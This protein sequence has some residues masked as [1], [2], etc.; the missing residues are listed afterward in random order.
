MTRNYDLIFVIADTQEPFCHVDYLAFCHSVFELNAR[1][2]PSERVRVIHVG[3]EVDQHT[4]GRW[5][6]DPNGR[7]GGDEVEEAKLRLRD[8]YAAFPQASVCVSNHSYRVFKKAQLAGIPSQF[9]KSLG[10]VYE[11]PPGWLWA[12]RWIIDNV[13]FEHGEFVSG[14]TAALNAATQNRMSTVIG[15]QHTHAGV[16]YSASFHDEIWG[17]NVGCGIDIEAYA[18]RYGKALRKK[19]NLG[20]GIILN[21]VPYFVPMILGPDKRWEGR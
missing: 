8:W 14:P 9:L 2:L 5:P 12:D 19:P 17:M 3:D 11:A 13:C 6:A 16:V 4:L 10:E 7:S 1:G 21:G 20:C 18:F 15:H